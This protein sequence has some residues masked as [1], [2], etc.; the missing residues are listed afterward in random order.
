MAT[1]TFRDPVCGMDPSVE[2]SAGH[3]SYRGKRHDFCSRERRMRF[4]ADPAP[5]VNAPEVT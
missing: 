4:Q 2:K 3:V 1:K 5:Y